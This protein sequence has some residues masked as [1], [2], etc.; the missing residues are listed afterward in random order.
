MRKLTSL[1]IDLLMIL[2]DNRGWPLRDLANKLKKEES[3][4]SI[5]LNRLEKEMCETSYDY[6][7]ILP[8]DIMDLVSLENK[9]RLAKDPV[10]SY[11]RGHL[12]AVRHLLDEPE[13]HFDFKSNTEVVLLALS[14]TNLIDDPSFFDEKRFKHIELG[15]LTI[16][17]IG[18]NPQGNKLKLLNR[19]L[20]EEAYPSEIAKIRK[21][22]V[23]E[24]ARR[25]TNPKSTQ[26]KKREY[27]L[28]IN[29]DFRV[30]KLI[31]SSLVIGERRYSQLADF[32]ASEYAG[33]FIK[34]FGIA[35]MLRCAEGLTEEEYSTLAY[36]ALD[37]GFITLEEYLEFT[38]YDPIFL[39]PRELTELSTA[40]KPDIDLDYLKKINE[41]KKKS[42]RRKG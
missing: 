1:E 42:A 38:E 22:I 15:D 2:S 37:K 6:L 12:P 35:S 23:R 7:S 5:T 41:M 16:K 8:Y 9:L 30:F 31:V 4:L 20:L 36:R 24:N 10:S 26:R 13:F 33:H 17:L 11:V 3:N 21:P 40:L 19:L 28:Y 27:P 39:N 32:I 18:Q 14:L 29:N 34:K 25:T